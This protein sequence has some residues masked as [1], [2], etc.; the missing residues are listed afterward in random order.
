MTKTEKQ[1]LK[2]AKRAEKIQL[3]EEKARTKE[4]NRKLTNGI[5]TIC[6]YI[7]EPQYRDIGYFVNVFGGYT[8]CLG[9]IGKDFDS[10]AD[11]DINYDNYIWSRFYKRMGDDIKFIIMNFPTDVS[12]QL[13]YFI[14]L[15]AKQQNPIL[16]EKI[17]EQIDSLRDISE[18][19]TDREFLLF[20]FAD[21][22]EDLHKQRKDIINILN[23]GGKPLVELLSHDKKEK[24]FFKLMNKNT[25]IS[26]KEGEL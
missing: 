4:A 12:M 6:D 9:I 15:Y 19:R 10:M 26:A 1:E 22:V 14:N 20:F 18:N 13:E 3:M 7:I 23:S 21:N 24:V 16:K 11:D 2:E 25:T 17:A 5:L 8:D